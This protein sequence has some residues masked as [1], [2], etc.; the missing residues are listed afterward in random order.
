MDKYQKL[1]TGE[2]TTIDY[3]QVLSCKEYF[4]NP[5]SHGLGYDLFLKV[6]H[7][8]TYCNAGDRRI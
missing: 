3:E 5:I 7:N 4:A 8:E 6:K 2:Q 1:R